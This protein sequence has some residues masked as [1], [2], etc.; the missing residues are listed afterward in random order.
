MRQHVGYLRKI[1]ARILSEANDLKRTPDAL[2]HELRL[3]AGMLRSVIEGE[4]TLQDARIVAKAMSDAYP[5]SLADL[6]M[7]DD[8]TDNGVV[9]MRGDASMASSRIFSRANR[10]GEQQPYYEYRDTAM[11][12]SG[13]FK[14]E[15]IKALRIVEDAAGDNPDVAYNNGHLL[16]QV[17]FFVG[18]VNF[19]WR[20]DG[21]QHC[22]EFNTG[23]SNFITPFTPHSF[24]S[25]CADRPGYIVAVTYGAQVRRGLSEFGML[26]PE[27]A[28]ALAG[29]LR[30]ASI[31]GIR[32]RRMMAEESL[33]EQHLVDALVA[34]NVPLD[35]ARRLLHDAPPTWQECLDLAQILS[36]QPKDLMIEPMRSEGDVVVTRRAD[37]RPR[38]FPDGDHPH[39]ELRPLARHGSQ[40]HVKAFEVTVLSPEGAPLRHHLHQYVYNFGDVPARL[41][42]NGAGE[43]LLTPGDSAYCRPMVEHRFSRVAGDG[44]PRLLVIRVPG[45]LT[46]EAVDE[47]SAFNPERRSRAL[48]ETSRWF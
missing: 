22:V 34:R 7:E 40:P 10:R 19:Y 27:E 16:H 24:A 2:A 28:N 32:L 39:Y 29:D 45:A 21:A 46:Q 35:R 43:A 48:L 13:P 14:P 17:T 31:F 3:D 12:R 37:A 47:Y 33:D 4:A 41:T 9:I 42:W 36:V 15:W 18:A 38:L 30:D 23:D 5:I 8:D 25:R 44:R 1:G 26:R 11:S 20:S 6:W